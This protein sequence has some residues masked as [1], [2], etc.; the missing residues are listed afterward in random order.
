MRLVPPQ[1]RIC[2]APAIPHRALVWVAIDVSNMA[3]E[4]GLSVRVWVDVNRQIL[5][6]DF[7][8]AKINL[9]FYVFQDNLSDNVN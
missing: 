4:I 2:P 3:Q 8:K 6:Y 1:V 5:N 9:S 7:Y